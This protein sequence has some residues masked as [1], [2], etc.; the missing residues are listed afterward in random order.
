ML[1]SKL[2][3]Q[4]KGLPCSSHCHHPLFL[5]SHCGTRLLVSSTQPSIWKGRTCSSPGAGEQHR[6]LRRWT[7][8]RRVGLAAKR[9]CSEKPMIYKP[10][11]GEWCVIAWKA[12]G[13]LISALV[14][15][16]PG[17]REDIAHLQA[18]LFLPLNELSPSCHYR[19][20]PVRT[21]KFQGLLSRFLSQSFDNDWLNEWMTKCSRPTA[22]LMAGHKI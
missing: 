6:M 20:V 22:W 21:H 12:T 13:D 19:W 11:R 18:T 17:Y 1:F 5:Y 14:F 9:A 2:F 15:S 4:S 16:E 7:W 10:G 3:C 8:G